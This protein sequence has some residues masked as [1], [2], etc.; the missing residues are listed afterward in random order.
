MGDVIFRRIGGH[1]VPIRLGNREERM[2]KVKQGTAEVVAGVGVAAAG[3]VAAA[4][5]LKGAQNMARQSKDTY[6][7][8]TQNIRAMG[9][10]P[11]RA[12]KASD[13]RK[14]VTKRLAARTLFRSRNAILGTAATGAALLVG[15]GINKIQEGR[16]AEGKHSNA[17]GINAGVA[18]AAIASGV[19]YKAQGFTTVQAAINTAHR[20]KGKRRPHQKFGKSE[21]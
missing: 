9:G 20:L 14:A 5:V 4:K 3:G 7:T 17:A 2:K 15:H 8:A 16:T 10:S 1:I 13:V 11:G 18:T 6:R 12:K 19:Y 21:V